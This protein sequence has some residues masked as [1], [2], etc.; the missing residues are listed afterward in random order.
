MLAER[1][2]SGCFLLQGHRCA[3]D[4]DKP[5][6]NR[7]RILEKSFMQQKIFVS[8]AEQNAKSQTVP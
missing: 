2:Q 4:I 1:I 7:G 8:R 6:E 5:G 3:T